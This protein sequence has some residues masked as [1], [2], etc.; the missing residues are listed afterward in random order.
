MTSA[1]QNN[2]VK[3]RKR[4]VHDLFRFKFEKGLCQILNAEA[5]HGLVFLL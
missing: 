5:L 3:C 1:N 4:R 2:L